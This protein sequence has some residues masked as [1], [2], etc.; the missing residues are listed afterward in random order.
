M[1]IN[2]F[3]FYDLPQQRGSLSS[4]GVR[5]VILVVMTSAAPLWVC[6]VPQVASVFGDAFGQRCS[7]VYHG[8]NRRRFLIGLICVSSIQMFVVLSAVQLI[9]PS[10]TTITYSKDANGTMIDF[11]AENPSDDRCY[12]QGPLTIYRALD[13]CP[14]LL[15]NGI[16]NIFYYLGEASMY[17][18]PLGV[19][20]LVLAALASSFIIAPMQKWFD[21]EGAKQVSP[22]AI[23][24]GLAGSLFCL[25]ERTPPNSAL[26]AKKAENTL[27]TGGDD[28]DEDSD[29]AIPSSLSLR[30]QQ[31]DHVPEYTTNSANSSYLSGREETIPLTR[32]RRSSL[33]S[34]KRCDVD[35]C[36]RLLSRV[37]KMIRRKLPLLGPFALLSFAYAL[38]FVIMLY[39]NDKCK[40]NMWGYNSYDQV[41]LPLYIFGLFFIVDSIAP[42]RRT[43]KWDEQDESMI[44][45]CRQCFRELSGNYGAGFWNMFLYRLLINARAVAYTYITVQYNLSSSYLELTLIRVVLSWVVSLVLVLVVPSFIKSEAVEQLKLKDVV[46]LGLKVLGTGAIVGS[47]L[48]IHYE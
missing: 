20:M 38:Y 35:G 22:W 9:A 47:L 27:F 30:I 42:C 19:L 39:Y 34:D 44:D 36:S 37:F 41:T 3:A 16:L 5:S 14:L 10:M 40:V 24:L 13:L 1:V 25:I 33:T 4:R 21:L 6:F 8:G 11:C 15:V 48:I 46:N 45:A 26:K 23:V 29:G 7:R 12:A 17:R 2:V 32:G 18:E 28:G 43:I 31:G